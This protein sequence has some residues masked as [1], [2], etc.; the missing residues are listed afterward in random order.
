MKIDKYKASYVPQ[1]DEDEFAYY[2]DNTNLS[3]MND[4]LCQYISKHNLES[5]H[6][7][8]FD[9]YRHK[10]PFLMYFERDDVMYDS[11]PND[12][13][14]VDNNY[15]IIKVQRQELMIIE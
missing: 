10:T 2:V 5:R 3:T 7:D 13:W 1:S 14:A 6:L 12:S 9:R 8:V 4:I 15:T 11:D